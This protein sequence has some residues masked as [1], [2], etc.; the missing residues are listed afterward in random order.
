MTTKMTGADLARKQIE[1][2]NSHDAARLVAGYAPDA[3]VLDPAYPEPLS[4]RDAIAKDAGTFFTGF[5]DLTF[6]VTK[7]LEDSDTVALEGMAAGTHTGPLQMPPTGVIPATNKRLEFSWA[8]F[9]NLDGDGNI[10]EERRYYDV[11]GQL[12]QL[13]IMQ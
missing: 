4:G 12:T 3:T 2:W 7:V 8:V 1:A 13:G 11:A 6:R 5:P 10:R 9:L